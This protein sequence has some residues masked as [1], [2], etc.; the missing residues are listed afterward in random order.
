MALR[1]LYGVTV[2]ILRHIDSHI[3][4]NLKSLPIQR[5]VGQNLLDQKLQ[6]RTGCM[7]KNQE[8]SLA[9]KARGRDKASGTEN[10]DR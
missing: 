7:S 9:V 3:T 10:A 1:N 8:V 4:G 2:R 6:F 5:D